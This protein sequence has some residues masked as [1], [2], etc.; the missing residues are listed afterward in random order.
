MSAS[1]PSLHAA[2]GAA[3]LARFS[4]FP[5][6]QYRAVAQRSH[7][8]RCNWKVYAENY[9]EGY[10]LQGAVHPELSMRV[11]GCG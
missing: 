11:F 7:L 6:T 4:A 2:L 3:L 1:A 9:Q 10:H 8:I 5:A